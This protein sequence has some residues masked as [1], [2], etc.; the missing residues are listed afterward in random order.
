MY[1]HGLA[2]TKAHEQC[3]T[4][5]KMKLGYLFA[6]TVSGFLLAGC[7]TARHAPGWEYKVTSVSETGPKGRE[8]LLNTMAKDGWV[9]TQTDGQLFY[10]KRAKR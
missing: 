2:E 10:F 6:I 4:F 9:F 8:E 7:C 3:S 1:K 5:M